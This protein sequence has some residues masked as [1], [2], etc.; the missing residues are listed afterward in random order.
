MTQAVGINVLGFGILLAPAFYLAVAWVFW[1]ANP[2]WQFRQEPMGSS[3]S[4]GRSMWLLGVASVAV[5]L[6]ILP[7]TQREQMLATEVKHFMGSGRIAEGLAVMS[8]HDP[9][10]FPPVFD[11][12][13]RVTAYN[14]HLLDFLEIVLDEPPAPW[15]RDLYVTKFRH[16]LRM[17]YR[18]GM[19][20]GVDEATR[21][22]RLILR[23]PEGLTLMTGYKDL[24]EHIRETA[25]FSQE[26]REKW[27]MLQ[28]C[29]ARLLLLAAKSARRLTDDDV[30]RE[31][32]QEYQRLSVRKGNGSCQRG[33][34]GVDTSGWGRP[35]EPRCA[36][37]ARLME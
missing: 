24:M 34:A 1:K 27:D 28:Y 18:S 6:L 13:P 7:W 33:I 11:P 37:V 23:L 12:P 17:L 26:D 21:I 31:E 30:V 14:P 10:D 36:P 25:K 16:Y 9:G 8:A 5:W 3:T 22:A 2:S 4:A 20:A 32:Y 35:S 29:P 15:V 19:Y